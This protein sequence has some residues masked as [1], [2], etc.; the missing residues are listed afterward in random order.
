MFSDLSIEVGYLG[1][2]ITRLGVPDVNWNQLTAEQL[3]QG[4]A[5]A[6]GSQSLLRPNPS[7]RLSED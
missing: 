3:A 1:S 5:D 6:I 7:L 2:K 4:D